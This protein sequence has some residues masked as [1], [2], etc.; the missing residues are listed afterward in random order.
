M[1]FDLGVVCA[2][3]ASTAGTGFTR[4]S[5]DN[6][7]TEN[8]TVNRLQ[9]F[10]TSCTGLEM[11]SFTNTSGSNF[12]IDTANDAP[13]ANL[14]VNSG[15]CVTKEAPGDFTAY[16]GTNGDYIG[17]CNTGGTIDRDTT[18]GGGHWSLNDASCT[19]INDETGHGFS[20]NSNTRHYIYADDLGGA[21]GRPLP[22]RV[23]GGPFVGP[24]R[25]PM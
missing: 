22:Q 5:T 16:G 4:I 11:A 7:C 1:A 14:S 13:G 19:V 18:G 10:G 9:V 8:G 2:D 20:V 25:G 24:L 17:W 15:S 12:S 23:F 21:G 6:P 3:G